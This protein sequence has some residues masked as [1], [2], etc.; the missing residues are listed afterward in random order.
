[1]TKS[2]TYPRNSPAYM[3]RVRRPDGGLSAWFRVRYSAAQITITSHN[4]SW[5]RANGLSEKNARQMHVCRSSIAL[6]FICER[7]DVIVNLTQA[8]MYQSHLISSRE[9]ENNSLHSTLLTRFKRDF[10]AVSFSLISQSR[11]ICQFNQSIYKT[12]RYSMT[13]IFSNKG[14]EQGSRRS[15]LEIDTGS[16]KGAPEWERV[17]R[18]A[19]GTTRTRKTPLEIGSL[20]FGKAK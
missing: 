20:S 14:N 3:F 19:I 4:V 1:M 2:S 16:L 15:T 13:K 12:R 18:R 8:R 10:S 9:K 6:P 7:I 17:G 5:T 11:S